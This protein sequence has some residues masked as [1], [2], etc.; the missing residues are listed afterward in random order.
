[1]DQPENEYRHPV[2]DALAMR[3]LKLFEGSESRHGYFSRATK[4]RE[5]DGKLVC[6]EMATHRGS[7]TLEHWKLHLAGIEGVGV[8]PIRSDNTSRGGTIDIDDY[9]GELNLPEIAQ[10]L[11][12]WRLP[13]LVCRT[14]SF[15]AH[16]H[17]F[18][19]CDVP[20]EVLRGRLAEIAGALAYP[21]AEIF[22]KQDAVTESDGGNW[23]AMPY[24]DGEQSTRYAVKPTGEA[25]SMEEFLS[26]AEAMKARTGLEWFTAPLALPGAATV[27][28]KAKARTA[29]ASESEAEQRRPLQRFIE[30]A[31]AKIVAGESRH[32]STVAMLS[33]MRDELYT[34]EECQPIFARWV[35]QV[36]RAAPERE[37]ERVFTL[38][39][40]E[41]IA[42]HVFKD[43]PRERIGFRESDEGIFYYSIVKEGKSAGKVRR[44]F[45]CGWL[46][47]KAFART[48]ADENW[49]ML[50]EFRNRDG[51]LRE[52]VLKNGSLETP[53]NQ[54]LIDLH[55]AGLEIGDDPEVKGLLKRFLLTRD[56]EER[57]KRVRLIEQTGWNDDRTVFMLPDGPVPNQPVDGE[58]FVFK[59]RGRQQLAGFGC[60]GNLA[61]WQAYVSR[62]CAGNSR[63]VFAVSCAFAAPLLPLLNSA[64]GRMFHLFGQSSK[65]KTTCLQ[66]AGSV[67]GE[68][69]FIT[70][71]NSTPNAM[72][73]VAAA[74]NHAVLPLDELAEMD[75]RR[76]GDLCYVMTGGRG[77]QRM[78][79]AAELRESTTWLNLILSS[80]EIDLETHMKSANP[81]GR[82]M[83]GQQAR[84]PC[85]RAEVDGGFG[86]FENLHGVADTTGANDAAAFADLLKANTTKYYGAVFVEWLRALATRRDALLNRVNELMTQFR[87]ECARGVSAQVVRVAASF[88]L[89]AAAGEVATE[90][91]LT[92]WEAGEAMRG[93]SA[94][95]NTWRSERAG[96]EGSSDEEAAVQK[97]RLFFQL[98]GG[99]RF[100][101]IQAPGFM[102]PRVINRAGYFVPDDDE[103]WVFQEV[104]QTEVC[105]GF[106]TKQVC[107]ALVKRGYLIKDGKHFTAKRSTPN[108]GRC[109]FYVMRRSILGDADQGGLIEMPVTGE[110]TPG[111][112]PGDADAPAA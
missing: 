36:K 10:R 85:I 109:R 7:A 13:A 78:N 98:H 94:C 95:F 6:V 46:R 74:Y 12:D 105:R 106:S 18:A 77:K 5:R 56:R 54:W 86:V 1:M 87:A 28:R 63:L 93:V 19:N 71:W 40:V 92:G 107:A 39:E 55:N 33:V 66:V 110:Q 35:E 96:G 8:Q 20:A 51:R 64:E 67:C 31:L 16:V 65:G 57:V 41:K 38:D 88:S 3:F 104:F 59:G 89:A 34:L 58:E 111:D 83:G 4:R 99:S 72:E 80:G 61:D 79:R 70:K 43:P 30:R 112:W 75:A 82:L 42:A 68:R 76:A 81:E 100:E 108:E 14:K 73:G 32:N 23:L 22:P 2:S 97:V 60:K 21:D 25:Y 27:Q 26:M 49:S 90:V 15:G 52:L 17:V 11:D 101:P 48:V 62:Y 91:G 53:G 103:F 9:A 84:F 29:S 102:A 45:V 24:F 37:G 47:L 44:I 50:L 69:N